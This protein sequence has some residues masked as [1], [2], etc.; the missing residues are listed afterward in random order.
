MWV[1][2]QSVMSATYEDL[3]GLSSMLLWLPPLHRS[4]GIANAECDVLYGA[5]AVH[6]VAL[7]SSVKC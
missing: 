4:Y 1:V 7:G 6:F 2:A 5:V 3:W